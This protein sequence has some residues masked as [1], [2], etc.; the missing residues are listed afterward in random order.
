VRGGQGPADGGGVLQALGGLGG[1]H[2]GQ[3]GAQGALGEHGG[4]V[5][6]EAAT[7]QAVGGG[8]R[9]EGGDRGPERVDVG[10]GGDLAVELLGRHVA[11]G[12]DH[13]G[14]AVDGE[15]DAHAAE[16][17]QRERAVGALRAV[18]QVGGLDVAVDD[19]R[20]ASVEVL[21]DAEGVIE[22]GE[23]LGLR[24]AGAAEATRERLPLDEL[25]HEEELA[26]G[27][28]G[29]LIEVAGDRGVLEVAQDLALALEQVEGLPVAAE[30]AQLEDLDRHGGVGGAVDRA[31]G[32]AL[33][34]GAEGLHDLVALQA[35]RGAHACGG[36]STHAG[37][38]SMVGC[39]PHDGSG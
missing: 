36:S 12:A 5:D 35:G 2:L 24:G 25:H 10:G 8:A 3:D 23:Q 18:D 16:V 14:A 28:A 20:V 17:D 32:L 31:E 38:R 6:G 13:G 19:R 34:A 4:E 33:R 37:V 29:E 30:V 26:A 27:V 9:G 11:E 7:R 1:E 21:E 39:C 22:E 15:G